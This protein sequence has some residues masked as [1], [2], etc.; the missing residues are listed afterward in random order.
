[1]GS[2]QFDRYPGL[3][4][5]SEGAAGDPNMFTVIGV[6]VDAEKLKTKYKGSKQEGYAAAVI[7][8]VVQIYR[9]AKPPP[10]PFVDTCRGGIHEPIIV[11][12]IGA[13]AKGKSWMVVVDGRQRCLSARIINA[14][15]SGVTLDIAAVF[16]PFRRGTAGLDATLVKVA[17]NCRV[18]RSY[19]QRAEDAADLTA[20]NVAGIAALVEAR[21]DAEVA[22]LLHL[23]QCS[24]AVKEAVDA[25]KVPLADAAVL[26]KLTEEEQ[27]RRVARKTATGG[28]VAQNAAALPRAK[29]R[30]ANHLA[31]VE[32]EV[33][34][35]VGALGDAPSP[36]QVQLRAFAEALAYARGG[37]PPEWAK[38]W[39]ESASAKVVR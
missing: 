33:L 31:A 17:S 37:E 29:T 18:A 10:A 26:R 19:S 30:R 20:R 24:D 8:A 6:D 28:R 5:R 23:H 38:K 35:S 34:A 7:D 12:D 15:K 1:M 14:E 11:C 27:A 39:I 36:G 32:Q 25:G 4:R 9:T 16:R 2:E 13:D 21:D 3:K 22:L